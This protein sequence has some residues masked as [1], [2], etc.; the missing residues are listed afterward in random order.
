MFIK[1]KD[2]SFHINININYRNPFKWEYIRLEFRF[3]NYEF[4]KLINRIK[5]YYDLYKGLLSFI[6]RK[7]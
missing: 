4:G 3:I 6:R 7:T 1:K 5:I 2:G